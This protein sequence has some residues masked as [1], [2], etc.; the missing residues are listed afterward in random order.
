MS[1]A[2]DRSR[3]ARP[4]LWLGLAVA[5]LVGLGLCTTARAAQM[6][7]VGCF[8]GSL[9][10]PVDSCKPVAEEEFSEEVQL[11][12]VGGMAVNYTGAGGVPAGTVYGMSTVGGNVD[13]DV[14]AEV[15]DGGLQ[16]C[17]SWK[18]RGEAG[19]YERCGPA[20]GVSEGK[21]DMPCPPRADEVTRSVDVDVDQATGNVYVLT[22]SASRP[23]P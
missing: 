17:Q 16:F 9:P 2:G 21:A 18:V 5:A 1:Q 11:G 8:A 6:E 4:A 10:G 7:Q 3:T 19:P 23:A 22:K 12:G 13:R 20:L 15:R 14:Y